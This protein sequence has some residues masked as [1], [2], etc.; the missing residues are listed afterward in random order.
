LQTGLRV[1]EPE[2]PESELPVAPQE[3]MQLTESVPTSSYQE[4]HGFGARVIL[5]KELLTNRLKI[6]VLSV[7]DAVATVG[8]T[9]LFLRPGPTPIISV[10]ELGVAWA[11][12][13]A[14]LWVLTDKAGK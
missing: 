7:W 9:A 8:A 6:I 14:G 11:G 13:F 4:V 3:E 2:L 12:I 10:V 5:T 1:L